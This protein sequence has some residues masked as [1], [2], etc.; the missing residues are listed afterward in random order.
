M[1]ILVTSGIGLWGSHISCN[2]SS[3]SPMGTISVSA[4]YSTANAELQPSYYAGTN[5]IA[6]W[7]LTIYSQNFDDN[8]DTGKYRTIA[9]EI[10]HAYGLGHVDYS[11]QI[12]YHTYS[13]NKN[14]TSYDQSGM[15]VMTHTHTHSGSY[16]TTF[17]EYSDY[18]HKVRCNTCRTYRLGTC[19]HTD[20][21]SETTH[22]FVFNC[23]CGND[24][25]MSWECFG[26]PCVMP[27]SIKPSHEL[28]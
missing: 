5:H 24:G 20:Y 1:Q 18:S 7:T 28:E 26:P 3:S 12:M 13:E 15:D 27:F 17:E 19:S 10:G 4:L 9:H 22:Y 21:H 6:Y 14:V 11:N 16:S 25:T 8:S 2:E 23:S